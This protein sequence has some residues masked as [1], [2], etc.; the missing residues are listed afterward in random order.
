MSCCGGGGKPG[1]LV[2]GFVMGTAAEPL[3]AE[4]GGR[5]LGSLDTGGGTAGFVMGVTAGTAGAEVDGKT[6]GSLNTGAATGRVA[7]SPGC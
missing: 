6:F 4:A 5:T 7:T 2:T 3:G 1:A